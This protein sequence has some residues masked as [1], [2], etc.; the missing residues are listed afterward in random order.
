MYGIRVSQEEA[1]ELSDMLNQVIFNEDYCINTCPISDVCRVMGVESAEDCDALFHSCHKCLYVNMLS[2]Y[3]LISSL[4]S[5][6]RHVKT[7]KIFLLLCL[8]TFN[9]QPAAFLLQCISALS[10]SM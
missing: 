4:Q 3:I 5:S 1:H 9:I 6:S 2:D 8:V 7:A 10:L